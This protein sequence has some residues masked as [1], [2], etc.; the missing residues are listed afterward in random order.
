MPMQKRAGTWPGIDDSCYRKGNG[1]HS[2][3]L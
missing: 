1:G 3:S 2:E